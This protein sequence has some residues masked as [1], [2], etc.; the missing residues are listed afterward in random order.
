MCGAAKVV[1]QAVR[2]GAAVFTGGISEGVNAASKGKIYQ[3]TGMSGGPIGSVTG[4]VGRLF[5]LQGNQNTPNLASAPGGLSNP[6]L[7]AQT[8]GAPVLANIAMGVAPKD[9]LAG[10]LGITPENWDNY[11][12]DLSPKDASSLNAVQKQ[13]E[14]IQSNTDLRNKA[15]QGV[16]NDFPN[17]TAQIAKARA[18]SGQEF[19]QVT[20]GYMKQALDQTAAKFAANGGLSSGAANEAFSK[21]GADLAMN[22]LDYMGNREQAARGDAYAGFNARLGEVNA[23]RDFQNTMLGQGVQQGF[24]AAQANLGR[25]QQGG[26][27][28][29]QF[30]NDRANAESAQENATTNALYG[31]LGSLGGAYIG[32][33]MLQGSMG[34]GAASS[35]A[36]TGS[37]NPAAPKVY[38]TSYGRTLG[39]N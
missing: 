27:A 36:M 6:D 10:F 16:I 8:G 3:K 38:N 29:A 1:G 37:F 18:D 20:Q 2:G 30:A 33:K 25:I 5:G 9:A 32:G 39:G 14:T 7:L 19:D 23:L 17:V 13:L 4:S 12:A 11:V 22:K 35:S 31:A 21:T 15:V 28:N 34:A 24:S 26:M